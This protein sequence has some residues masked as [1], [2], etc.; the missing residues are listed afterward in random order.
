MLLGLAGHGVE[1]VGV[2]ILIAE[3]RELHISDLA[4]KDV[5]DFREGI[6]HVW[7]LSAKIELMRYGCSGPRTERFTLVH[8]DPS[9]TERVMLER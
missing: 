9:R 8:F 3:A 5:A 2:K 7:E 1:T 4:D 6:S